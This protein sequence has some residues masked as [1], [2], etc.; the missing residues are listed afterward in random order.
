VVVDLPAAYI[1]LKQASARAGRSDGTQM[2]GVLRALV[3][4]RTKVTM[5]REWRLTMALALKQLPAGSCLTVR[6]SDG[7]EWYVGPADQVRSTRLRE[8]A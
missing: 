3:D 2:P 4:G 1:G 5:E 8:A 6:D 7:R